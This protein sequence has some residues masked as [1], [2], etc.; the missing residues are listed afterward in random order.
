MSNIFSC[1]NCG[2]K[3]R[4]KDNSDSSKAICAKCWSKLNAVSKTTAPPPPKDPPSASKSEPENNNKGYVW[5]WIIV[6]GGFIWLL[7]SP[8]SS[9]KNS[10]EPHKAYSKNEPIYPLQIMPR[11]GEVQIFTSE[12]TVAPLT[13]KTSQGANYLVKL[14]STYDQQPVMTIFVKGGRTV[15]TEVPLGVYEVKYAS[16]DKW[17]GYKHLFGSETNYSKAESQ[18][19]FEDDGHQVSGYTLTLYR[20]SNGNLRTSSINES[21]F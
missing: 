6:I 11:N 18:F 20:V 7:L 12:M 10:N 14:V 16:G 13:I 15:S 5:P 21:Q 19:T 8:A 17:Y 4:I 2:Q 3:N 1:P 9:T